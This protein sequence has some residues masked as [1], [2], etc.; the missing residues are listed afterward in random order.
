MKFQNRKRYGGMR[1]RVI[2]PAVVL[3]VKGVGAEVSVCPLEEG[4]GQCLNPLY[5]AEDGIIHLSTASCGGLIRARG[6]SL[7]K[8]CE[9]YNREHSFTFSVE[10]GAQFSQVILIRREDYI[11]KFNL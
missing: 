5:E 3:F 10:N 11:K 2:P 1:D 8:A 9:Q 6:I 7:E 4:V